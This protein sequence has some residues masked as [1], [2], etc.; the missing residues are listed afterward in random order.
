MILDLDGAWDFRWLGDDIDVAQIK[1][2]ELS[3]S[4]LM[5]V[6]GVFDTCA[7]YFGKRGVGVYRHRLSL[8]EIAESRL[9]LKLAGL[10]LYARI[11]WDG[12]EI[13]ENKLPYSSVD[14]DFQTDGGEHELVI[15]V[16]NRFDYQNVPLFS[17]NFDF[18]GYGGIY[19]HVELQRLPDRRLE[20]V[21]V[22][23][24]DIDTGTVRLKLRLGGAVPDSLS[25][26]VSFDGGP[27]LTFEARPVEGIV[28]Q[29]LSVPDFKLWSPAAPHLHTVR[30]SIAGDCIVERFGIRRVETQGQRILLNGEPLYLK[31]VNRHESHPQFGPVQSEHLMLDDLRI[32]KDLGCNFVRC[33]HYPQ[34]QAFLDR[35]D[36]LGMLVWQESMGWNWKNEGA[37]ADI[38]QFHEL[39]IEQTR[40]MVRNSVNHPSI[41]L[42]SYLN[43]CC[44]DKQ[45]GRVLYQALNQTIKAEDPAFLVTHASN[46]RTEDICFDLVDVVAINGYPGWIINTDFRTSPNEQ[47]APFVEAMADLA[48]RDDLKD[49]PLMISEMGTCALYGCHD[50]GNAQWSEEA[51]ASYCEEVC[52]CVMANPRYM[53]LTLWQMFDTRSFVNAG[54]VRCKPKGIN[55][56][57]LLDEYRRP[58]LAYN[59]VKAIFRGSEA[60]ENTIFEGGH[61]RF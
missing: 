17:P 38:P 21:Q 49:K 35:C 47:I 16:D 13:G 25:Y 26:T 2:A 57:G 44:S 8:P 61:R 43:E 54:N 45:S 24:K 5:A 11:W 9:R 52:R 40:L 10:G 41:I 12:G 28:S 46:K 19:R 30:V 34:D 58:K 59:T 4:E 36:Q 37:D 53:G 31:G 18:Y 42:W 7:D 14:Y 39:Q 60:R 50:M 3:Y 22:T 20:R 56:A 23:T 29:T 33:V 32:L 1:P 6:P 55:C 48:N 27:S 51:Q 15:A